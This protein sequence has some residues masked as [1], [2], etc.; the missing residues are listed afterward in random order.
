MLPPIEGGNTMEFETEIDVGASPMV[1]MNVLRSPNREEFTR[2]AF[3]RGRGFRGKS[4]LSI[5]SSYASTASD[6][7]S[8]APETAPP[9]AGRGRNFETPGVR[10]QKCRG[11]LRQRPPVHFAAG[12]PGPR[13]QHGRVLPFAGC[14][15]PDP[16]ARGL[17]HEVDLDL[18]TP[19]LQPAAVHEFTIGAQHG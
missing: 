3:Y 14:R 11:G 18:K 1:E 13:G 7:M 16:F 6:V 9:D 15:Q 19:D 12:L 2:I 4:L 5:D 8:R 17:S 10:G